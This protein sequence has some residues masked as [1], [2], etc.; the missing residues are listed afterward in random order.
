MAANLFHALRAC[1]LTTA[2][3]VLATVTTTQGVGA[4]ITNRLEKAACGK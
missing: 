3:V 2:D 1:D 4:A